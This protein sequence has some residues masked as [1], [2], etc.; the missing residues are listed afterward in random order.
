MK[1]KKLL[2]IFSIAFL[3]LY[4]CE[5]L[6][7]KPEETLKKELFAGY[8]Q[9]GPFVNG[10]SVLI[11]ELDNQLNQTGRTYSTTVA[12][13]AGSF[14]QK[15]I[16]LV[17]SYVQL[18]ADG[19]YFNEVSGES[20][21]GQLTLYAL[22]DISQVN[23]ANVNV[24]THLEKSRVEYLLQ[25]NKLTFAA[26]KKQ[27]QNEVLSIFNLALTVDSTSESLNLS[28]GGDNNAVLLAVSCILQ[29]FSTTA[30][31]SEL[32]GNI[33]SDI[34]TDG[35]LDNETLGSTLIDN[36]RLINL[37]SIR[38]H[39]ETKYA[40]LGLTNVVPDF[41]KQVQ[42]F[43][44]Q[45]TYTPVK[46]ITYPVTGNNGLNLLNDTVNIIPKSQYSLTYSIK[47]ELPKGTSLRI[48]LKGERIW[49]T[50]PNYSPQTINWTVS[51]Y[52][53]STKSQELVVN[54]SDME[55]DL[56]F[57]IGSASIFTNLIIE[58]YEN[59]AII[60]TRV[61]TIAVGSPLQFIYPKTG[62][63]GENILNENFNKTI[64]DSPNSMR[65]EAS[66]GSA[67]TIIINGGGTWE[68]GDNLTNW[69]VED[70]NRSKQWQIFN[71]TEAY[72]ASDLQIIF[73]LSGT[74]KIDYYENNDIAPTRSKQF[75]II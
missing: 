71:I 62:E 19:Y 43:L 69:T 53:E 25:E 65:V 36:A 35:T 6:V 13:N 56:Y 34:K 45:S 12:D 46:R 17:S 40:E 31:M 59:G 23:S 39:L 9:K 26:A 67:L 16:E 1:T 8:V 18:K 15:K 51:P 47:A 7:D 72:K 75:I 4:S 37:K 55:T 68:I 48:V 61:K 54:E 33:I 27:A 24:L 57:V 14:E 29:G 44:T 5:T 38:E 70:Y 49:S 64:A 21:S 41:E 30:E 28:S 73:T 3:F 60:P 32:M 58:Y 42:T 10:S 50:T 20:S 74:Y 22:A 66:T 2:S 11:S 63:Y 52:D